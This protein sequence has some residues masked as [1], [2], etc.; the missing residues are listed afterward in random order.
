MP[1][2]V[3]LWE[4]N[5]LETRQKADIA[6]LRRPHLTGN[7]GKVYRVKDIMSNPYKVEGFEELIQFTLSVETQDDSVLYE[8]KSRHAQLQ[9]MMLNYIKTHDYEHM[10]MLE[11]DEKSISGIIKSINNDILTRG[12]IDT[13]YIENIIFN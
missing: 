5:I 12:Y 10:A 13:V 4:R 9:D 7:E 2:Y 8:L 1:N 3:E 11:Y 6:K